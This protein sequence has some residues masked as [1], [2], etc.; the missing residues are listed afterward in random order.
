MF[1]LLQSQTQCPDQLLL[2][3]LVLLFSHLLSSLSQPKQAQNQSNLFAPVLNLPLGKPRQGE[4]E[5]DEKRGAVVD[6]VAELGERRREMKRRLA[7]LQHKMKILVGEEKLALRHEYETII[8][9]CVCVCVCVCASVYTSYNIACGN[10]GIASISPSPSLHPPPSTA[11]PPHMHSSSI[12]PGLPCSAETPTAESQRSG[13]QPRA[14][15]PSS[16]SPQAIGTRPSALLPPH[17][18]LSQCSQGADV[19]PT[20][21]HLFTK[22]GTHPCGLHGQSVA[23][24]HRSFPSSLPSL[25]PYLSS[26]P[27]S[28][29]LTAGGSQWTQV[30][31]P[32]PAVTASTGPAAH[33]LL[34]ATVQL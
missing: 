9:V 10:A 24:L 7:E 31:P 12:H 2:Q 8:Q 27:S 26:L 28:V 4:G 17:A 30:H 20:N 1:P 19:L 6:I 23:Q 15:P 18:A 32:F 29:S 16:S 5:G 21:T 3:W 34:P 11:H 22:L 13:S 14:N 33:L 25:V